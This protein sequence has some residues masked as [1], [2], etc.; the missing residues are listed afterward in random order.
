MPIKPHG[1]ET[2]QS[3][4]TEVGFKWLMAGQGWWIDTTRFHSEAA[5]AARFLDSAL[6][7]PSIVLRVC[8]A[9]MQ[10]DIGSRVLAELAVSQPGLPLP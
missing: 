3:M 5:Y 1:E 7:S 9:S 8:T 10:A 4:L 2:C 6:K